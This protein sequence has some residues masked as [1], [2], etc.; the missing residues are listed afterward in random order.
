MDVGLT[1]ACG[2]TEQ[3]STPERRR[4]MVNNVLIE[5]PSGLGS[6]ARSEAMLPI[7]SSVIKTWRPD[8][9]GVMS[10]HAMDEQLFDAD[11]PFLDWMLYVSG[12]IKAPETLPY[13]L[14]IPSV[15]TILLSAQTPPV[16]SKFGGLRLDFEGLF[17][18]ANIY[19]RQ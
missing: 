16:P 19:A 7:L 11:K 1:I 3:S 9:A 14:N 18:H 10:R 2:F 6:L 8:W 4:L 5:W 15:G 17:D 12:I 13:S